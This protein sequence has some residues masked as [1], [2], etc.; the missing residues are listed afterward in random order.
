MLGAYLVAGWRRLPAIVR[1]HV[2]L[3]RRGASVHAFYS[4]HARVVTVCS[5]FRGCIGYA[6]WTSR[7]LLWAKSTQRWDYEGLTALSYC[8]CLTH[9]DCIGFTQA[10]VV[11]VGL[12]DRITVDC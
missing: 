4:T 3:L 5:S 1:A 10:D 6:Q 11:A 8:Y 12:L 9:R 2:L 7:L